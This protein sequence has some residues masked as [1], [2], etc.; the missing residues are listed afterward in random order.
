MLGPFC[1][2]GRHNLPRLG[3]RTS[4]LQRPSNVLASLATEWG[5]PDTALQ[6]TLTETTLEYCARQ[7][8]ATPEGAAG[9]GHHFGEGAAP[10]PEKLGIKDLLKLFEQEEGRKFLQA[11]EYLNTSNED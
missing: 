9:R 3:L 5:L 2:S 7:G 10:V 6:A 11:I 8:V 1:N 4:W